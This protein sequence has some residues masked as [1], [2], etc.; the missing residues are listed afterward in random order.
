MRWQ[1]RLGNRRR[2]CHCFR[3]WSLAYGKTGRQ[4]GN[5][6]PIGMKPKV[7]RTTVHEGTVGVTWSLHGEC[8]PDPK[9]SHLVNISQPWSRSPPTPALHASF[10]QKRAQTGLLRKC[11]GDTCSGSTVDAAAGQLSLYCSRLVAKTPIEGQASRAGAMSR[12]DVPL[13][14][15]VSA[16]GHRAWVSSETPSSVPLPQHHHQSLLF[17]EHR[18][19]LS[20]WAVS[21]LKATALP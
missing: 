15:A 9:G 16:L 2:H 5:E 3:L 17:G 10:L 11:W 19:G 18:Q 21:G 12:K 8:G 20:V 1:K 6:K 7:T 14:L 4:K 13:A